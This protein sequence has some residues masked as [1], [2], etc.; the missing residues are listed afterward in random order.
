MKKA[1]SILGLAAGTILAGTAALRS[2]PTVLSLD[3]N[4]RSSHDSAIAEEGFKAFVID[5]PGLQ[6]NATVRTFGKITV[7][8]CDAMRIGYDDR[9]RR[10]AKSPV[11]SEEQRLL[12]DVVFPRGA[13]L[14]NSLRLRIEG[15]NPSESYHCTIWSFDAG[16][17]GTRTS[18]WFANGK[19]VKAKYKFNG[20][21]APKSEQDFRFEFDAI[22][23]EDGELVIEGRRNPGSKNAEGK[24]DLGV[25]L[26]ALKLVKM[27]TKH[28]S[29]TGV[30]VT[31]GKSASVKKGKKSNQ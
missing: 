23:D 7:T 4:D 24:P 31:L 21:V 12:E 30:G 10:V 22:A 8:L 28:E 25:F 3:F 2:D 26:N 19:L 5:A 17:P 6:T 20:E 1:L 9:H 27:E 16:S 15:L 18:D 11:L 14:T 13:A 29:S